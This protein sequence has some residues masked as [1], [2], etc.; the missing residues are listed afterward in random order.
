MCILFYTYALDTV[1]LHQAYDSF[2]TQGCAT[3]I[4]N[5]TYEYNC[6]EFA[7]DRV[8]TG[9]WGWM[10]VGYMWDYIDDGS[11]ILEENAARAE[12]VKWVWDGHSAIL[13]TND[14]I[15]ISKWSQAWLVKHDI[16]CCPYSTPPNPYC[17]AYYYYSRWR[18]DVNN[19]TFPNGADVK[20]ASH[21]EFNISGNTI[22][23][24]GAKVR[25]VS[26]GV[27]TFNSGFTVQNGAQFSAETW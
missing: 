13:T 10:S 8:E 24:N 15:V 27:M 12:K 16:L 4:G 5:A 26:H 14:N 6:H 21:G 9:G 19:K 7:W 11:Y 3:I 2:F 18:R 1:V 17:S 23:S 22:I 20:M 25:F